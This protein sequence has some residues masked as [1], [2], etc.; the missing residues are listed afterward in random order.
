MPY[1]PKS[2]ENL[3]HFQPG[4]NANPNGR[5]PSRVP[6]ALKI[7]LGRKK[8]RKFYRLSEAEIN[9]WETNFG[10]FP[11]SEELK[12]YYKMIVKFLKSKCRQVKAKNG[13]KYW[14][15]KTLKEKDIL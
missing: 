3:K 2:I 5:P 10:E 1:N 7:V 11:A 6:E 4:N 9:E 15:S 13:K 8:A 14:V 12:S